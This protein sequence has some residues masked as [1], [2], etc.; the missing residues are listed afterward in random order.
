[1]HLHSAVRGEMK[2]EGVAYKKASRRK[3]E[4]DGWRDLGK[5]RLGLLKYEVTLRKH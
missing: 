4:R 2:K 5:L 3:S 1:M